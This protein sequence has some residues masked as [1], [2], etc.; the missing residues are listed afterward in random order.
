MSIKAWH[1]WLGLTLTALVAT[2]FAFVNF[3]AAADLGYD[4]TP[5]G[6]VILSRWSYALIGLSLSTLVFLVLA[7]RSWLARGRSLSLRA[8]HDIHVA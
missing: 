8:D 6:K 4:S 3:W 2:V 7:V 5:E 1:V